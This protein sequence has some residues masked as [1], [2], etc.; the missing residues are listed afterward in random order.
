[1]KELLQLA[2]SFD[3]NRFF[4]STSVAC[5]RLFTHFSFTF[6]FYFILYKRFRFC[7]ESWAL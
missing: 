4:T 6:L 2:Q 5:D 3:L 7:A 1:M